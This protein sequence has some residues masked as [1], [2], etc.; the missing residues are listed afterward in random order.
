MEGEVIGR[1]ELVGP[2][3]S[4]KELIEAK[5]P[6]AKTPELFGFGL[7]RDFDVAQLAALVA[8]RPLTISEPSD[9]AR[10]ELAGLRRWYATWGVEA[11]PLR[12][13]P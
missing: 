11:D 12:P 10:A 4:L 6:Y 8:P 5:A 1:V 13:S 3:G 9:R 2:L 7:L